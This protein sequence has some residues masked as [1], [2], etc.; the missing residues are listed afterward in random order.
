MFGAILGGLLGGVASGVLGMS[1]AK[2]QQKASRQ[3]YQHRYQWT[4]DDLD[5]A[6]LNP[7]LAMN[8]GAVGGAP[9]MAQADSP[10]IG[11]HVAQVAQ[12]ALTK[13]TAKNLNETA[14]AQSELAGKYRQD[15][16]GS[17]LDNISKGIQNKREALELEGL[18]QSSD[19]SA[20][21]ARS[22]F[23]SPVDRAVG[24]IFE[25]GKSSAK[26]LSETLKQFGSDVKAISDAKKKRVEEERKQREA[27]AEYQRRR[28]SGYYDR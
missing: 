20:R 18:M 25:R 8:Q 13:S 21:A 23:S 4:M 5:K 24:D 10:D 16:I 27:E 19:A 3:A 7:M 2:Q 28:K 9:M 1:S 22:R 11:S 26:S 12:A 14:N 17:H 15:A 6:G